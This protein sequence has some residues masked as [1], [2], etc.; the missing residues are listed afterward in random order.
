M[1][2]HVLG[3]GH[4]IEHGVAHY[5]SLCSILLGEDLC[6]IVLETI[7]WLIY[8]QTLFAITPLNWT[9]WKAVL[10]ISAP[11]LVIDEVLK[12]ITVC[13]FVWFLL[14]FCSWSATL[15]DVH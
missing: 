14:P 13:P 5:D 4:H 10:L 11:V 3:W 9:E 2:E 1:E 6:G 12:F 8:L 7:R 15:D